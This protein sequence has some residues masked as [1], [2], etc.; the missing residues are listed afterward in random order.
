MVPMHK[1][2]EGDYNHTTYGL[3]GT[4]WGGNNQGG[5]IRGDGSVTTLRHTLK[6]L[7]LTETKG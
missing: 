6:I 1:F 7:F 5:A 3:N 4:Y 2:E